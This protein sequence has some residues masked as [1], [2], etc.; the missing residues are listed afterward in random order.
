MVETRKT[1]SVLLVAGR[2]KE[3]RKE[4]K[5]K[6]AE[7]AE[8]RKV[9]IDASLMDSQKTAAETELETEA[10]S[11]PMNHGKTKIEGVGQRL[12]KDSAMLLERISKSAEGK[13]VNLCLQLKIYRKIPVH[14]RKKRTFAEA[15]DEARRIEDD[16]T[17]REKNVV[18]VP[19]K[20]KWEGSSGSSN[21]K[22][23][24]GSEKKDDNKGKPKFCTACHSSH[25][26]P[27]TKDTVSCRRCGKMG[28]KYQ[29][30]KSEQPICYKCRKMGHLA[31]AC[32][33][34]KK[35]DDATA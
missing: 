24:T 13:D 30:C 27:C 15:M 29:D 6:D 25:R 31:A 17:D 28:H 9:M 32:T 8:M 14:V 11:M 23:K 22:K 3:L 21:K 12:M 5:K 19:E 1:T 33:E 20:R 4:M 26:G 35:M 34:E 7:M 2:V 16:L 10:K 18:K